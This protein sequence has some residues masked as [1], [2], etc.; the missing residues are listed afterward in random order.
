[1]RIARPAGARAVLAG[2][3][4]VWIAAALVLA[5]P[6][7]NAA[8]GPVPAG[9]AP[10]LTRP[11]HRAALLQA[12]QA[13]DAV[14]AAGCPAATYA[15]TGDVAMLQPLKLDAHGQ[16]VGGMWKESVTASGCDTTRLLNALTTVMANGTLKTRPLLPGTTITDPQLQQDSVQYAAAGMGD[17]PPGCDQGGVVDTAFDRMDGAPPGAKPPAGA[18]LKPWTETWTLQACGKRA[19]V[20]MHFTPDA[21][22][23][24]IRAVA[25]GDAGAPSSSASR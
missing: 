24:A 21:T 3:R 19:T 5:P 2:A 10:L 12:V 22:G 13:V 18:V 11:D 23:T 20:T 4:A 16:P 9:L 25:A 15:T 17:M 7:A 14:Q 1:M 8:D 6:P